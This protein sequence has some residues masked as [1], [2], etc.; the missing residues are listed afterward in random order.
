MSPSSMVFLSGT[1]KRYVDKLSAM[2]SRKRAQGCN[3]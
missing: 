3:A 1:R 2:G